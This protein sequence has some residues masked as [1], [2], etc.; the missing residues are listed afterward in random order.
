[1]KDW[2]ESFGAVMDTRSALTKEL[3]GKLGVKS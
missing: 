3:Y 1:M 2:A